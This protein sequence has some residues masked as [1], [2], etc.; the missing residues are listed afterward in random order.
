[1]DS[2]GDTR[3]MAVPEALRLVLAFALVVPTLYLMVVCGYL[4]LLGL[5]AW[6]FRVR[7][8]EQADLPRVALLI[9][10]HNEGAQIEALLAHAHALDYPQDRW[11]LFVIADNCSDDTAQRARQGGAAVFERH[12]LS[13]SGKGQA[14]D[15]CLHTH[16][17]ALSQYDLIALVD[18]D[19]IIHPRFLRELAC[20]FVDDSVQVVQSLNTVSNPDA[21]WRSAFGFMG[22]T[23]VNFTRPAGRRWL[24]GTAELRGSGMAFRA[25]LLLKH[26]WPA[27]SLAEDVEFS[28]RLLLEGVLIDFNPA[29]IVTS[30]I[31]LQ[32]QQANVQQQRWEGGKLHILKTYLP[33]MLRHALRHPSIA[34]VDAV[35][36]L[37]VP[38]QSVLF[39]LL[40]LCFAGAV[41][42]SPLWALAIAACGAGVGFCIATGLLLQRAPLKVWLYLLALPIFLAWKVPLYARLLFKKA[43]SHT[44][45]R[46]PRDAEIE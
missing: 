40:A 29:A 27:H 9:P 11:Q 15:W 12:D 7:R 20:S 36:D 16:A 19:M 35:I 2:S 28:K 33:L 6:F 38:P 39:L 31:P 3:A 21:S 41:F 42:V 17:A 18:A 26:G 1:M 30:P 34:T 22:F 44:W 4:A 13:R 24:G 46:T 14:L 32:A 43:E 45:N 8:A 37:L 23:T 5:G 25:P 10:A